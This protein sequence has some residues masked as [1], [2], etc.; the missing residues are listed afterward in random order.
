MKDLQAR[1]GNDRNM[2]IAWPKESRDCGIDEHRE[3]VAME[4][5]G[6]NA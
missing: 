3:C 5:A 4:M 2:N 6:R 1:H